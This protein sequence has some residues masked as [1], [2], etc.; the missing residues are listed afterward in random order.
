MAHCLANCLAWLRRLVGYTPAC[1][2]AARFVRLRHP[3]WQVW[4][5]FQSVRGREGGR[6]IIAVF[7]RARR[8]VDF[9]NQYVLVAVSDDM[10]QFEE[11]PVESESPYFIRGRK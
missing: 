1:R 5:D 4:T 8:V 10:E 7:Y 9:P 6:E 3:D 2:A 11:L